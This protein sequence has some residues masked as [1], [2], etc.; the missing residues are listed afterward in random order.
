[1]INK[2]NY[3]KAR[4]IVEQY[5]KEQKDS[6]FLIKMAK[7]QFPIGTKVMSKLNALVRG[8]IVDY[9]MWNGIVQLICKDGDKKTRILIH[10][11]IIIK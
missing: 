8:V 11:V 5:E 4:L 7:I 2:N 1:M 3:V 9:S 6:E 10:N